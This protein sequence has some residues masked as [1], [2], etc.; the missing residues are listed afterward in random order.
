MPIRIRAALVD[1][2]SQ[3]N[4]I[5][6]TIEIRNKLVE[7]GREFPGNLSPTALVLRQ[8]VRR[9]GQRRMQ[10]SLDGSVLLLAAAFEQFV[11]DAMTEYTAGLPSVVPLYRDLPDRVQSANERFTGQALSHSQYRIFSDYELRRFVE[12]LRNCQAGASPYVLNGEAIAATDRNLRSGVIRE[13]FS[14]LG[15]DDIWTLA[16]S[17]YSLRRWSGRGGAIVAADRAKNK[18]N[19]IIDKRNQIAHRVGSTNVGPEDVASY[20]LFERALARSLAKGLEN[21]SRTF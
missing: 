13:L 6:K 18:L 12:N 8:L 1:F 4:S 5:E 10:P 9:I 2:H 19:E 3:I 7:F 17:T 14:R 11:S 15:I 16:G 21:H 20:I